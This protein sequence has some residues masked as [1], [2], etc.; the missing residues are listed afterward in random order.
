[1]NKTVKI[2]KIYPRGSARVDI[3]IHAGRATGGSWY[4]NFNETTCLER[5]DLT[6][7]NETDAASPLTLCSFRVHYGPILRQIFH[8]R[9]SMTLQYINFDTVQLI[10]VTISTLLYLK[11][12]MSLRCKN[13]KRF[14]EG[15][16]SA[17]KCDERGCGTE[18]RAANSTS[19]YLGKSK[20]E[21]GTSL[22]EINAA[23]TSR[24]YTDTPHAG[25]HA[26]PHATHG[27]LQRR[28]KRDWRRRQS[29]PCICGKNGQ[30]RFH[31]ERQG[32]R[33]LAS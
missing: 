15:L 22:N 2:K 18:T 1:M 31:C 13:V 16:A 14:V 7:M 23:A 27:Q 4:E 20:V 26:L 5:N 32:A 24:T 33:A 9:Y 25:T 30:V 17:V 10:T 29:Q 28:I 6:S 3:N 19:V 8:K 21:Y 12:G 11:S